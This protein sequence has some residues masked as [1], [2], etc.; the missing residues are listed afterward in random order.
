MGT[1]W[2]TFPIIHSADLRALFNVSHAFVVSEC[3]VHAH[4]LVNEGALYS[5]GYSVFAPTRPG[6]PGFF[7][8]LFVPWPFSLSPA[9]C[10]PRFPQHGRQNSQSCVT[11]HLIYATLAWKLRAKLSYS[12]LKRSS[13]HQTCELRSRDQ[14]WSQH[15]MK[16]GA[17]NKRL[18]AKTD[19][20]FQF[21]G[22][23]K[24]KSA[25]VTA[26]LFLSSGRCSSGGL[27]TSS[28]SPG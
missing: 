23:K 18:R 4:V 19:L 28:S 3:H 13:S 15:L 5:C 14:K 9:F 12:V 7:V 22:T 27:H 17:V 20:K 25:V 24:L 10:R 21:K 16:L 11:P 26:A 1:V 8:G 2:L 6:L